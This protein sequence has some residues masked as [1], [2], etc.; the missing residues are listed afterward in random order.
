MTLII[1]KDKWCCRRNDSI[2][3]TSLCT[4]QVIKIET[5]LASRFGLINDHGFEQ[6]FKKFKVGSVLKY[7]SSHVARRASRQSVLA[8]VNFDLASMAFIHQSFI[9]RY[10]IDTFQGADLKLFVITG[11]ARR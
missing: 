9:I 2:C 6:E 10:P 11:S 5:S 1:G 7:D 4:P 8:R 3:T